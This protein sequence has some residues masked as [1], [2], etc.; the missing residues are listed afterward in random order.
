MKTELIPAVVIARASETNQR[1]CRGQRLGIPSRFPAPRAPRPAP[2]RWYGGCNPRRDFIACAG[3]MAK[4]VVAVL[5]SLL[6]IH[7]A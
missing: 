6:A 2:V 5:F 7:F 1:D 3:F 4:V